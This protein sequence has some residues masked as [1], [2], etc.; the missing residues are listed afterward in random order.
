MHEFYHR[1]V[2]I[3]LMWC[4]DWPIETKALD[5]TDYNSMKADEYARRQG[6]MDDIDNDVVDMS[7]IVES[8]LPDWVDLG[9][10]DY[11]GDLIWDE[12]KRRVMLAIK[13]RGEP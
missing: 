2:V 3:V 6:E 13:E 7:V 1:G 12:A 8:E 5:M 11:L 9:A 4:H 10:R